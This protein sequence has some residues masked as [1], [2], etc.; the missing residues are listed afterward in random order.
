MQKLWLMVFL[1]LIACASKPLS[2][3]EQ[4][5]VETIGLVSLIGDSFYLDV[6]RKPLAVNPQKKFDV[7]AWSVDESFEIRFAERLRGLG[8]RVAEM[9][10]DPVAVKAAIG[11]GED[12]WHLPLKGDGSPL[13]DLLLR[14][15]KK[16]G[17]S[18]FL[19]LLPIES[20]TSYPLHRGPMGVYCYDRILRKTQAAPYFFLRASFWGVKEGK[21]LFAMDIDPSVT[22]EL[23]FASCR[24]LEKIGRKQLVDKAGPAVQAA[25]T[26]ATDTILRQ[27][28]WVVDPR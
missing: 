9:E 11:D 12:C 8:R 17:I 28:G 18:H 26:K 5:G 6:I 22:S 7:G 2:P 19:L 10:L 16:R 27:M 1:G 25:V 14:E 21:R 4:A 24:E 3:A 20:H 15:A 13:T 23:G